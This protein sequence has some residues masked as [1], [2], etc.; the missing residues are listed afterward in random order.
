MCSRTVCRFLGLA[1]YEFPGTNRP[2]RDERPPPGAPP[3][4]GPGPPPRRPGGP[5]PQA[6]RG[7]PPKCPTAPPPRPPPPRPPSRP[8]AKQNSAN[9]ED[10]E[11]RWQ[12]F[13]NAAK[14]GTYPTRG[15]FRCVPPDSSTGYSSKPLG[16]RSPAIAPVCKKWRAL[17]GMKLRDHNREHPLAN[18]ARAQHFIA[19]VQLARVY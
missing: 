2:R 9:H 10:P 17:S 3:R 6:S 1:G 11:A 14:A 18:W 15:N 7:P 13:E 16:T 19:R 5:P 4:D 12:A 8:Q